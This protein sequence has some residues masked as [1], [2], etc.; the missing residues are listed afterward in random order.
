MSAQLVAVPAL[1]ETSPLE[2][3]AEAI[4]PAF[5]VD[6]YMPQTDDPVLWGPACAVAGCPGGRVQFKEP[7]LCASHLTRWR[8]SGK[9]AVDEFLQSDQVHPLPDASDQRERYSFS[10]DGTHGRLRAELQFGLQQRNDRRT[11]RLFPSDFRSAVDAARNA[12]IETLIGTEPLWSDGATRG[13]AAFLRFT[14]REVVRLLEPS[15]LLERDVW[16]S[17]SFPNSGANR[18]LS[19]RFNVID[20]PWL[21]TA[22]KRWL[23]HRLATGTKWNT[24]HANLES[25]RRF[26]EF[27]ASDEQV[28]RS[29]GDLDRNLLVD[30]LG[31]CARLPVASETRSKAV[32]GVRLFCDD[33]RLN[34]WSP[35]L[36]ATASIS[37]GEAPSVSE[38]LPRPVD[39]RVMR[40]IED[41]ENL[42]RLPLSVVTIVVIGI[43]C[44]LRIG[45]VLSLPFDPM[46]RDSTG[47]H[48][49]VYRNHKLDREVA[50]P[51]VHEDVVD[52]IERQQDAVR[53]RF[54]EGCR[55][56]F[57]RLTGNPDGKRRVPYP[58]L[59]WQLN[60]WLETCGIVDAS[61]A[62]AHV[63]FH[64]FRH[65][66]G[67]R[68]IES[69]ASGH[70]V[71]RL[72]DHRNA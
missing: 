71:Q 64:Q 52:V 36:P 63:T 67:T 27:L 40:Q 47:Q 7:R 14:E 72:M 10:L 17:D 45:D 24:S 2:A 55:W 1:T 32:G 49:L 4:R 13:G 61:G 58:T 15:D 11:T 34:G 54:P 21:R 50:L 25:M 18:V 8:K 65:T 56:L 20:Q 51:V 6:R 53:E 57:P 60:E 12:G 66:F 70:L 29:M 62:P 48:T 38:R 28:A 59:R 42:A 37:R 46:R 68:L 30:Y 5:A 44:G 22:I 69:G 16:R 43:R 9:P 23:K 39:E 3:L 26:S 19:L 33:Y 31:W 41:E 35:R